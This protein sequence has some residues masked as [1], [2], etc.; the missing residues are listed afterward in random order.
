MIKRHIMQQDTS[1]MASI[2]QW[3]GR[4]LGA[5]GVGLLDSTR[6]PI[7]QD[8]KSPIKEFIL[9]S[10]LHYGIESEWNIAST[11]GALALQERGPG[12]DSAWPGREVILKISINDADFPTSVLIWHIATDI[13]Y[14]TA[15]GGTVDSDQVKKHKQMSR[16]LSNYIMYLLFK[17]NVIVT[18]NSQHVHEK[19]HGEIE[20][21]LGPNQVT[22][23]EEAAVM[24]LLGTNTTAE[25]EKQTDSTLETQKHEEL[26]NEQQGPAPMTD[27]DGNATNNSHI[28]KL[29]RSTVEAL[30]TP[31]LPRARKVANALIS[32]KDETK[33]WDLIASVWTEMLFY[34]APRCGA[35]FHYEHL[36][37]GGE[38]ATNVLLLMR[39]L[40][41]FL[42]PPV[43]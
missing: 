34:T 33:R 32:I 4:H 8:H 12:S 27:K 37:T 25:E 5:W 2:W 42:P 21:V 7:A 22:L 6:V 39:S 13:C 31:V 43:A 14:Y 38:F 1:G 3:M 11:R 26:G 28:Q 10:L 40:G 9:D 24:K 29:V 36:S 35:S 23:G 17:C 16:E 19:V 15:D 18:T 41:P 20:K 30:D